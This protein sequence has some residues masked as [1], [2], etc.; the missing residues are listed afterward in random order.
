MFVLVFIPL[1]SSLLSV[2]LSVSFPYLYTA[3]SSKGLG[4][5]SSFPTL[6][7]SSPIRTQPGK[8]LLCCPGEGQRPHSQVVHLVRGGVQALA[9][10]TSGPAFSPAIGSGVEGWEALWHVLMVAW[11][12]EYCCPNLRKLV[13]RECLYWWGPIT[14]NFGRLKPRC[15]Q[16]WTKKPICR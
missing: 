5:F 10:M 4:C 7:T 13:I 1:S 2:C 3:V 15:S 11:M 8:A 9:L 6:G 12:R 14:W 16:C